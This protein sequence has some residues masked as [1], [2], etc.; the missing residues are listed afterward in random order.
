MPSRFSNPFPQFFSST[1]SPLSGAKLFF[2]QA[3]TTTKLDTFSDT[4][5]SVANSNPLTLNSS[6]YAATAIYM[7][8]AAYK[9]VLAPSTDSD[10]P[11]SPIWTADNYH[12]P[13]Y[14]VEAQFNSYNGNPNGNVAGTAG[15]TTT[16]ADSVWDY[17][18]SILY[19]CTTSGT[20]STAV[21]TALNAGAATS[22]IPTPQGRLTP[23]AGGN[24]VIA[25]EVTAATA[26]YY[27]PYVGDLIPIYNGSTMVARQFT[28]LTLTLVS[29]HA[30][31]TLYD[32]FMFSNAGVLTLVT[33]PAW[34][35]SGAGA[36]SRGTGAGTTQ[37]T[38]LNGILTNFVQI[39]GR[40]GSTTYTVAANQG[41]YLG[42]ILVDGSAG[43]VTCH[44]TFGQ[45]RRWA[46]WNMYNRQPI[47]LKCGDATA[48]WA[49]S[50]AATRASRGDSANRVHCL[51][52]YPEEDVD[53]EFVQTIVAAASASPTIGIG[54]NSTS[55]ISG[56]NPSVGSNN[57]TQT[58]TALLAKHTLNTIPTGL[59]QIYSLE[60]VV[61]GSATYNGGSEGM[62][63]QVKWRG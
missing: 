48:S 9:V 33:G 59:T 43:Q 57:G 50:T 26:V 35:A 3:G 13:E 30:A 36:G 55:V 20:A 40:N 45:N 25:S 41:T 61:S 34:S 19:V 22:I 60:H 11:T 29:A 2:Y 52:G 5:L 18:N 17:A 63:L 32:V 16:N 54:V 8:D 12:P 38:R 31:D 24:P 39:T 62:Q 7:S 4:A 53:C 28:E 47:I 37:L 1:P 46:V 10:P 42:T 21:W 6:G 15:T 49:Y 58:T 56:S 14:A 44:K 51:V 23:T 27:T